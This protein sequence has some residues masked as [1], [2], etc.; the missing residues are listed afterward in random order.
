MADKVPSVEEAYRQ[1]LR[2][3]KAQWVNL[4]VEA[5]DLKRTTRQSDEQFE[6]HC[7]GTVGTAFC[8][9]G[10]VGTVFCIGCFV[11]SESGE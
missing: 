9:G 10:C 1:Y 6:S 11:E 5:L 4:D 3:V 7:V 8:A 2:A